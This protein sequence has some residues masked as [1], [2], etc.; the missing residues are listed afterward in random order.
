MVDGTFDA[1]IRIKMLL[2][3][4]KVLSVEKPKT[5]F[6]IFLSTLTQSEYFQS[7]K[8]F[9][10]YNNNCAGWQAGLLAS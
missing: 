10:I 1:F 6:D 2:K 5:G 9:L 8:I 7:L 4:R 3:L